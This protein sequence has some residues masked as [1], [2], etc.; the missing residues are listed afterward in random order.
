MGKLRDNDR[1]R[2]CLDCENM[3]HDRFE[4]ETGKCKIDGHPIDHVNNHRWC[5]MYSAAEWRK[6]TEAEYRAAVGYS[7]PTA[8]ADGI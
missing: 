3:K 7:E 8:M 5:P 4:Y 2:I 6:Q 1:N